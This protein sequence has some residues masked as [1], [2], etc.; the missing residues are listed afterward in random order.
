MDHHDCVQTNEKQWNILIEEW[1]VVWLRWF[2][3]LVTADIE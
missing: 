3:W 1:Q 2:E